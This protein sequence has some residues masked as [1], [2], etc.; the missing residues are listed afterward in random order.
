MDALNETKGILK[1]Y[2]SYFLDG[3]NIYSPNFSIKRILCC[4]NYNLTDPTNKT[5]SQI[6]AHMFKASKLENST[7]LWL[8]KLP[9]MKYTRS[10]LDSSYDKDYN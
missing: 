9:E 4:Y 6:N 3:A 7:C 10:C 2:S 5:K 1:L 8:K